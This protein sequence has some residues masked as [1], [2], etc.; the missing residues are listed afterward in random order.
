MLKRV[1][2]GLSHPW[3]VS[4]LRIGLGLVFIAASLDKIQNPQSFADNIANYRIMPYQLINPVAVALPW[5]EFVTGSLLVMGVWVRANALILSGM[6]IL[7]SLAILQALMRNLD[8]SCG[9]FS[10]DPEAH[11][12]TRWTL[13]WNLIWLWWGISV[14]LL[15]QGWYTI[16]DALAAAL[17]KAR[18][19][20]S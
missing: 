5:V 10:T 17:R 15:D 2:K 1:A 16:A 7:F 6:L 9:C 4:L 18:K 19:A 12:M 13:Y 11:K 14:A 8:I 3:F 20:W